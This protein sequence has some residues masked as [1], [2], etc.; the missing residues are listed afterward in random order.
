MSANLINKTWARIAFVVLLLL[1]QGL[2]LAGDATNF[3]PYTIKHLAAPEAAKLVAQGG[4]IVLDVR[5]PKEFAAGHIA[6]A[7]N[8]D[9]YATNFV[10]QLGQ[11]DKSKPYLLHCASGAR[12]TKCL[13]HLELQ[14]FKYILHLDGG[15][16][17]W[18]AAGNPVE[19]K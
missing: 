14:G 4:L 19:K 7:T 2:V 13:P 6:G 3:P 11:L 16:N 8:I 10:A 15:F 9:Y 5:T 12:S 18:Q 1:G 17:A